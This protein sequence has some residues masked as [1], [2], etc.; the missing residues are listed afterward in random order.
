[1]QKHA[2]IFVPAAAFVDLMHEQSGSTR[3]SRSMQIIQKCRSLELLR[4]MTEAL[5]SSHS[6]TERCDF[7]ELRM[8]SRFTRSGKSAMVGSQVAPG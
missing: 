7:Q 4:L 6:E 1:M 3:N 2:L 8:A 5:R